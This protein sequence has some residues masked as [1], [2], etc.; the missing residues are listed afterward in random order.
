MCS[1]ASLPRVGVGVGV[2]DGV[3]VGDGVRVRDGV[4]VRNGARVRVTVR[5][6]CGL[7]FGV[8]CSTGRGVRV[9]GRALASLEARAQLREG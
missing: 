5:L 9:E 2:R 7:G 4:M 8:V 6:G 3:R 1:H